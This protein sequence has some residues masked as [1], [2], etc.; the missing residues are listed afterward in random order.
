MRYDKG[1]PRKRRMKDNS[2]YDRKL[3]V[4]ERQQIVSGYDEMLKKYPEL[5]KY[6]KR[7]MKD[8]H[9]IGEHGAV[10][11]VTPEGLICAECGKPIKHDSRTT[12]RNNS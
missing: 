7:R 10:G 11:F 6:G 12:K 2:V 9:R 5:N 1:L 8:V 4:K 3:T